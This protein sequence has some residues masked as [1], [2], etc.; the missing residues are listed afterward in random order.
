MV[1]LYLILTDRHNYQKHTV[2]IYF[3]KIVL[4]HFVVTILST[5]KTKSG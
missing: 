2:S 1:N 5:T 3:I 4:G